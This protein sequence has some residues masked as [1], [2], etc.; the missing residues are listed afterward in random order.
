MIV[1]CSPTANWMQL[2]KQ[3]LIEIENIKCVAT[4]DEINK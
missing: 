1:D 2:Y 3:L 4:L